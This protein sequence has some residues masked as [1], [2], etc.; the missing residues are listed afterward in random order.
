MFGR[1]TFLAGALIWIPAG[2][3][4]LS[5]L[6]AACSGGEDDNASALS[7]C[8]ESGTCDTSGA[9][10]TAI[11]SNHGHTVTLSQAEVDAGQ[12]VTKQLTLAS[13]HTHDVTLTA[14]MLQEVKAKKLLR[15]ES[16]AGS[17]DSHT[18]C[19]SFNCSAG[20]GGGYYANEASR[21]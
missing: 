3:A 10:N 18:H 15:L 1:R 7:T 11:S 2:A 16:T 5:A 9:I 17:T 4:V 21:A 6:L 8:S 12:A 20:G 19:V 13:G 14:E